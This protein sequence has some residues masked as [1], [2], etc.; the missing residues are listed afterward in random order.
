MFKVYWTGFD[1]EPYAK[2]FQCMNA[3]LKFTQDLRN[4][5]GRRFVT[6]VSENPDNVTKLGVAD[7]E[8]GYNW[9]KRRI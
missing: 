1:D 7:V 4:H 3:A 8:P 9:K 6:M 2:N 5:H